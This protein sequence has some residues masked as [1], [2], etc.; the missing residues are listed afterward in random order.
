MSYAPQR[1]IAEAKRIVPIDQYQDVFQMSILY[2]LMREAE[3]EV[4]LECES[5][6][7]RTTI[8]VP[9]P[10]VNNERTINLPDGTNN[11]PVF[12]AFVTNGLRVKTPSDDALYEGNPI[13]IVAYK[14]LDLSLYP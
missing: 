13:E 6:V 4:M 1:L 10:A 7:A 2:S 11:A 8:T 9:A 5:P 12:L 14:D 3:K